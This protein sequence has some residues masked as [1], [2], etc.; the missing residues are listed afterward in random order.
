MQHREPWNM[1]TSSNGNIFRVT[2]L[3][4]GEITGHRWIPLTNPVTRSF[5]VVFDLHLNKHLSK[6]SS[7]WWFET[8]S[9]SL[10]H[11]RNDVVMKQIILINKVPHPGDESFKTNH[12]S[13][14]RD[15]GSRLCL[16]LWFGTSKLHPYVMIVP[17]ID[18]MHTR[19]RVWSWS[20]IQAHRNLNELTHDDVNLSTAV[21]LVHDS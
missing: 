18:H 9:Y 10:L 15:H 16:F 17:T 1:M 20:C 5:D 7:G 11:H 2:G 13:E 6:Q 12:C 8:S 3:Y 19:H 4:C 14:N 21:M